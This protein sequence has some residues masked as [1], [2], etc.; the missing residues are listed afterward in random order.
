MA[1]YY[2]EIGYAAETVEDPPDSGIWVEQI[3]EFPYSGDVLRNTRQLKPGEGLNSDI[4][5][6]NTISIVADQF[7]NEHFMKIRYIRWAGELWTVT[8]VEVK[9]P[10]LILSLGSVYNGETG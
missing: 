1:R 9:A 5:V 3:E 4:S 7:A 10:R 8:N 2:G 6:G